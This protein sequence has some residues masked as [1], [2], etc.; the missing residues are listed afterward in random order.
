VQND[1]RI[2]IA[3]SQSI[4]LTVPLPYWFKHSQELE[5][6]PVLFNSSFSSIITKQGEYKDTLVVKSVMNKLAHGDNNGKY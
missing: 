4:A 6:N 5:R 3:L 2:I 1:A